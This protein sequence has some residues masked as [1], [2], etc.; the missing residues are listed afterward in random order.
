[1]LLRGSL[2]ILLCSLASAQCRYTKNYVAAMDAAF[3][4]PRSKQ[5]SLMPDFAR[6]NNKPVNISLRDGKRMHGFDGISTGEPPFIIAI[7]DQLTEEDKKETLYH[8]LSHIA[9]RISGVKQDPCKKRDE[10]DSIELFAPGMLKI[11]EQNP[12]IVQYL[13]R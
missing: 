2:L 5:A 6:I 13:T 12:Q 1:V 3:M 8:E 10:D 4:A 7:S 11:F 9:A